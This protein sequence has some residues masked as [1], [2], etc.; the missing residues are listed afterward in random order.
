MAQTKIITATTLVHDAACN[1]KGIYVNSTT[2]GT[3][4]VRDG[5]ASGDVKTGTITPAV[6]WVELPITCSRNL[7]ITVGGTINA[8][9]MYEG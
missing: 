7:H 6:G 8:S 5:G 9:V 4:V 3:I 1:L 2:A